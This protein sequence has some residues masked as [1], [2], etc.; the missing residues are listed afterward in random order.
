MCL[1]SVFMSRLTILH[2][3]APPPTSR[4][5]LGG[6][7]RVVVGRHAGGGGAGPERRRAQVQV[8]LQPRHGV[9]VG[10]QVAAPRIGADAVALVTRAAESPRR[11]K[12]REIKHC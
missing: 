6:G 1:L 9:V 11:C 12:E 3:P 10:P 4:L 8:P 7:R 5:T 2:L